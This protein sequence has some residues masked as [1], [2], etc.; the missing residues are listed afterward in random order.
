MVGASACRVE[1][2]RFVEVPKNG[3]ER[4]S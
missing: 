1:S 4:A 2:Y 3:W